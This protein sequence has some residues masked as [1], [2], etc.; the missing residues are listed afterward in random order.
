MK[1]ALIL[2]LCLLL[3]LAVAIGTGSHL[4]SKDLS[5]SQAQA[6]LP[7]AP[8]TAPA[9]SLDFGKIPIYFVP[10]QGQIDNPVSFYI[11]GTGETIYFAPDG[12]TF[13]LSYSTKPRDGREAKKLFQPLFQ[14]HEKRMDNEVR[15]WTA[16]LDFVGARK[17]VRPEGLDKTGALISYFTGK[18]EDWKAALTA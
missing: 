6:K 2:R 14:S 9:K 12:V 18:P 10:N 8:F 13:A 17:E 3:I 16:K 4:P 11:Q 15:R 1:K 7:A 5:G